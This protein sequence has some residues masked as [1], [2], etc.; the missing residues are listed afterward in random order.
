MMTSL[1]MIFVNF[2]SQAKI[3]AKIFSTPNAQFVHQ[4]VQFFHENEQLLRII[5][6]FSTDIVRCVRD[7]YH[8]WTSHHFDLI[9]G[10]DYDDDDR[11]NAPKHDEENCLEKKVN[12]AKSVWDCPPCFL[13]SWLLRLRQHQGWSQFWWCY[14][15]TVVKCNQC[16]WSIIFRQ[17][18]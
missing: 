9:F 2:C 7:K 10:W 12:A 4:N 8:V 15:H 14:Y 13:Y 16:K 5:W 18:T 3:L 17:Y 6:K 1:Y 11:V